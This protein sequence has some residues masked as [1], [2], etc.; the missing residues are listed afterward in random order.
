MDHRPPLPA[1]PWR[2]PLWVT[3]GLLG[4]AI[5]AGFLW[6]T[7]RPAPSPAAPPLQQ[8]AAPAAVTTAVPDP[9]PHV[10][11]T[12]DTTLDQ[13]PLPALDQSDAALMQALAGWLGPSTWQALF[14][15]ERLVRRIVATIDNLP[16]KEAP[17]SMW[18]VKPADG[19]LLTETTAAGTAIAAGNARRYDRHLALLRKLSPAALADLYRRYYP[20]FQ[21]AYEE[22]GY[23]GANF[24]DR[25][26]TAIDDL[27][28]TPEP[29]E[30]P[31]LLPA[32][33]RWRFADPDLAG[34]S[35]GQKILLRLGTAHARPAKAWLRDFRQALAR[36]E[37]ALSPAEGKTTP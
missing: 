3:A 9:A 36:H 28:A 10:R 4:A 26:R 31:A 16:R 12:L 1:Q 34:R 7:D 5:L 11:L 35:A 15:P 13:P 8:N 18:P 6:W 30:A 17:V 20:L 29:T 32:N 37:V 2:W 22:L 21:Q 23:P 24:H 14:R 27:L 25:L 19:W 33:V